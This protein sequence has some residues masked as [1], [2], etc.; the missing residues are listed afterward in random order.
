M[1]GSSRSRVTAVEHR[2]KSLDRS[3]AWRPSKSQISRVGEGTHC[4]GIESTGLNTFVFG[5]ETEGGGG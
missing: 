5:S 4:S 2:R 3:A 1:S